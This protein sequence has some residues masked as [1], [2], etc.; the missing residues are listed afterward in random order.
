MVGIDE[1]SS[2]IE[3]AS[4][5]LLTKRA[6]VRQVLAVYEDS[7]KHDHDAVAECWAIE[8]TIR[9]GLATYSI[10]EGECR[11][12]RNRVFRG[13]EEPSTE[14]NDFYQT[15]YSGWLEITQCVLVGVEIVER[16]FEVEG[17]DRLRESAQTASEVLEDWQPPHL[18]RTIGM[19]EMTLPPEAI[20]ELEK[21]LAEAKTNPPVILP[22][23][24]PK[25]LSMAEFL[26]SSK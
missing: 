2:H 12:W 9:F 18:T 23:I 17:A 15:I 3:E 11:A 4:M 21:I 20:G 8:D 1:S 6:H 16:S 19:R 14:A 24:T 25:T 7:W 10:I 13:I 26:A 5:S 22:G